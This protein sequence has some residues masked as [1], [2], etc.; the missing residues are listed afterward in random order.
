[1]RARF[2]LQ[3]LPLMLCLVFAA[4]VSAKSEM[5]HAKDN[6]ITFTGC[7]QTGTEANTFI[8]NNI[9]G[10]GAGNAMKSGSKTPSRMARSET[11]TSCVLIPEGKTSLHDHVGERVKVTGYWKESSMGMGSA[12]EM[13]GSMNMGMKGKSEFMVTSVHK[14]SGTC[15]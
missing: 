14:A 9:S 7:L 10:E 1:M 2:I 12:K 6:Q 13:S 4:S 11:S 15:K 3:A 8:L 5:M